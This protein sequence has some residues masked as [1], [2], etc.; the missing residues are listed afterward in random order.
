MINTSIV[1][2][3]VDLVGSVRLLGMDFYLAEEAFEEF[4]DFRGQGLL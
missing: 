2:G 1:A 4:F 3:F